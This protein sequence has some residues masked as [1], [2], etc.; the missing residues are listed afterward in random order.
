MRY[1]INDTLSNT[2]G[3]KY[4]WHCPSIQHTHFY[5]LLVNSTELYLF[6]KKWFKMYCVEDSN[7]TYEGKHINVCFI[8]LQ[9]TLAFKAFNLTTRWKRNIF[10]VFLYKNLPE[11]MSPKCL[12]IKHQQ[13][14]LFDNF[15]NKLD[16][17]NDTFK[18]NLGHIR[19]VSKAL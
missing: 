5:R 13:L 19:A 11:K 2:F 3:P 7:Y 17:S 12:F 9:I 6:T 16:Y 15:D 10:V 4:F 14:F 1:Q 18:I 8:K